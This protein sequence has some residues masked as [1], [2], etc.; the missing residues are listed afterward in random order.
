MVQKKFKIYLYSIT[1]IL[2]VYGILNF[3]LYN[4]SGNS[5]I[6]GSIKEN[7]YFQALPI[8]KKMPDVMT[9][10]DN[11][12]S[13][14]NQILYRA[15]SLS[16]QVQINNSAPSVEKKTLNQFKIF[17]EE[18]YGNNKSDKIDKSIMKS[19][20]N[21]TEKYMKLKKLLNGIKLG[22]K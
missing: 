8:I 12:N 18:K 6:Q 17:L 3:C 1:I 4:K 7:R 11:T 2:G 10:S 21:L 9:I 5:K 19:Q 13:Q 20:L 22:D 15:D 14:I 16:N